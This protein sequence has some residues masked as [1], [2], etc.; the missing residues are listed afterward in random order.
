VCFRELRDW[1]RLVGRAWTDVGSCMQMLA[2][3]VVV[4]SHMLTKPQING[5]PGFLRALW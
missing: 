2:A 4:V 3:L 1:W 5:L